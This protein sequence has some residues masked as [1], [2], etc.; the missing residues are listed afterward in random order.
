MWKK[1]FNI[2]PFITGSEALT[3]SSF[4]PVTNVSLS[5]PI[6]ATSHNCMC[7]CYHVCT[8]GTTHPATVGLPNVTLDFT[9]YFF[10]AIIGYNITNVEQNLK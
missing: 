8:D 1:V 10:A 3:W 6:W 4:H 7:D 2:V 9:D 5:A